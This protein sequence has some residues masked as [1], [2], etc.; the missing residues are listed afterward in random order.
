M[1]AA[2]ESVYPR[3]VIRG[4]RKVFRLDDVV[5]LDFLS[6]KYAEEPTQRAA[7]KYRIVFLM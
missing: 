1:A 6:A 5:C 7:E 3:T 4:Y 2:S